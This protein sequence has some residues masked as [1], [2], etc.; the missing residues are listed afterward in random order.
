MEDK[1]DKIELLKFCILRY[2]NYYQGI[3]NKISLYITL[4]TFIL[5]AATAYSGNIIEQF[6]N[7]K[8]LPIF[9]LT[10]SVV[11]SATSLLFTIIASIPF[12]K[13]YQK[14]NYYFGYVSGLTSSDYLE[15]IKACTDDVTIEDL[16]AQSHIL[17]VGLKR[18]FH[19]LK[20]AGWVL[21]IDLILITF[22]SL[23][24]IVNK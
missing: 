22:L 19:H 23:I 6:P 3:N 9:F 5:T 16:A 18:K 20:T 2:D 17:S 15:K 12:L 7:N 14:S 13:N 10:L 4:N 8:N 1:N 24:I 21:F 11:A